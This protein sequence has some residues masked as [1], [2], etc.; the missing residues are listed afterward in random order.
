MP[1]LFFR[2]LIALCLAGALPSVALAETKIAVVDFQQALNDID[3]GATAMARLEGMRDEKMRSIEVMRQNLAAVQT[4]IQNQGAI[5]SDAAMKAKE[6]EFMQAQ[7]VFQ[8]A[9]MQAEQELQNSYMAMMDEFIGKLSAVAEEIGKDL[10]YNL[11]LEVNES[12]V[13]YK[14]GVEDITAELVTRYNVKHSIK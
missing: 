14:T 11:V 6:E 10:G 5:L 8:Q 13:V 4:E 7:M 1:R 2:I 3:E 9:A 12:G